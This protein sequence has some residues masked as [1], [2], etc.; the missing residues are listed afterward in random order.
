M[1]DQQQ[2]KHVLFAKF[3]A[4]IS[5]ERLDALI[6]GYEALPSSIEVMKGFEWGTD[7][8]IENLHE[9]YTHVFL[10]TFDSIEGRDAYLVH[11]VHVAYGKELLAALEK[12]AVLDFTPKVVLKLNK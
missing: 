12:V 1:A 11:P 5:P 2:V 3:K 10:S 4:D 9:G 8:S 6:K 7:V